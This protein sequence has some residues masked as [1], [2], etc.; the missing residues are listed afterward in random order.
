MT[1][2][3]EG[4]VV[5]TPGQV[6]D[7]VVTLTEQVTR[8]LEREANDPAPGQISDLKE[9]A[10]KQEARIGAL[11]KKVW[12]ASGFAAALGGLAGNLLPSLRG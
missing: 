4:S 2:V 11:E 10:A 12:V 1:G 5:I 8:L 7:K 3:P 6:Y 9:M